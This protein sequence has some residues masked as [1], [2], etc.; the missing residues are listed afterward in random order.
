MTKARIVIALACTVGVLVGCSNDARGAYD[1][2]EAGQCEGVDGCSDVRVEYPAGAAVSGICTSVCSADAECP[3][4]S[5]G[6]VGSC[7]QFVGSTF[8]V[9]FERC[10]SSDDCPDG[11]GCVDRLADASGAEVRFDP[12]CLPVLSR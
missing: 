1:T 2:C 6:V 12:V 5:R 7:H 4:D 10:T 3:A 9:C 11:L 8:A